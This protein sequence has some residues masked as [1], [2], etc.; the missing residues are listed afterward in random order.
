MN[1]LH[2]KIDQL[3]GVIQIQ[4]TQIASMQKEI[5]YLRTSKNEINSKSIADKIEMRLLKLLEEFLKRYEMDHRQK[6][7]KFH[8]RKEFTK[9][10]HKRL[11]C[12][13]NKQNF[14]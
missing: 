3:I 13:N 9:K 11:R 12:G 1:E 10:R 6:L 7:E 14:L 2:T 5:Y 8:S 4:S